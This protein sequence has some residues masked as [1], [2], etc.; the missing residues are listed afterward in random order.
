MPRFYA[1]YMYHMIRLSWMVHK[2]MYCI[3][4]NILW[5]IRRLIRL[6]YPNKKAKTLPKKTISSNK[7]PF[8]LK[9]N[10]NNT[11]FFNLFHSKKCSC[12]VWIFRFMELCTCFLKTSLIYL[13]AQLSIFRGTKRRFPSH[14]TRPHNDEWRSVTTTLSMSYSSWQ[15]TSRPNQC[16]LGW[17]SDGLLEQFLYH[18]YCRI[19]TSWIFVWWIQCNICLSICFLWFSVY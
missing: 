12:F 19:V 16:G 5:H 1:P 6:I 17:W 15:T 18:T 10:I 4:N 14:V 8:S 7:K 2:V 9:K 11:C 3:N 13:I